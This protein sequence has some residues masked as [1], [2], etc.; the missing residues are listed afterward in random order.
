MGLFDRIK[1]FKW[2]YI[3]LSLICAV[4]GVCMFV[5]NNNSLA[6][7]AI[8]IG[9]IVVLSSIILAA[10]S[11]ADRN[12]G[13]SFAIK[14][15][16]SV[17]MLI[18]GIVAIIVSDSTIDVLI[19]LFGLV[20]IIDGAYK[21]HTAAIS[22]RYRKVFWWVLLSMAVILIAG[23]YATVRFL[24][25]EFSVTVYILGAMFIID[26]VANAI[27]AFYNGLGEKE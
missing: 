25:I 11:F 26:A 10:L 2:G 19:G 20:F 23:G 21:F 5:Y 27:S 1:K 7:L 3:L 4:I 9:S 24:T 22:H 15:V 17:V 12:R 16:L 18:T 8:T 14:I 13:F 6:A